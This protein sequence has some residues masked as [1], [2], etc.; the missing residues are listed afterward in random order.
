MD[1]KIIPTD[2]EQELVLETHEGWMP[3]SISAGTYV[4]QEGNGF[5]TQDRRSFE[6]KWEEIRL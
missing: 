2:P 6:S 4:I 3:Y 1:A 5:R